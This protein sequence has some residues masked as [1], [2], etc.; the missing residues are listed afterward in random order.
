MFQYQNQVGI[1]VSGQLPRQYNS[2]KPVAFDIEHDYGGSLP[3]V[4]TWHLSG[5]RFSPGRQDQAIQAH[6]LD[7]WVNHVVRT[8]SAWEQVPSCSNFCVEKI[9][10]SRHES[11]RF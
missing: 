8:F 4:Y 3:A 11:K 10:A 9:R 5:A 2:R 7:C 6:D 1:L